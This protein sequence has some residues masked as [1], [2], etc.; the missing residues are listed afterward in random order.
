M[1]LV[2]SRNSRRVGMDEVERLKGRVGT[3]GQIGKWGPDRMDSGEHLGFNWGKELGEG[4]KQR[5]DVVS[6]VLKGSLWLLWR[7]DKGVVGRIQ[8]GMRERDG[9]VCSGVRVMDALTG[10]LVRSCYQLLKMGASLCANK[11]NSSV[12]SEAVKLGRATVISSVTW[13]S[14]A[15]R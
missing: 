11:C 3:G 13:T 4:F 1:W 14:Q 9:S 15:R 6:C 7:V 2:C 5:S 12:L 8:R 10:E